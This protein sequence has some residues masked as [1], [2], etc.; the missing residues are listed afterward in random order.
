MDIPRFGIPEKLADRMTMAEQHDCLRTRRLTRR[1]VLRT[2]VA[3]AA[4]EWSRVRCTG[5][6]FLAVEVQP[7]RRARMKVTA[8]AESGERID[9][10]GIS[11]G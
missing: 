8:L 4:V 1:G 2:S 11:R 10:F 6:S 3:T 9:H 7:G 5:F